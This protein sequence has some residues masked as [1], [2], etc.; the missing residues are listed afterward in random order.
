MKVD[1]QQ[2]NPYKGKGT[3]TWWASD[4]NFKKII[5][6]YLPLEEI[7]RQRKE[8]L[9]QEK[10]FTPWNPSYQIPVQEEQAKPNDGPAKII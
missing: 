2:R 6:T 1:F 9:C 10:Q 8:T 4:G 3:T 5:Y 7:R